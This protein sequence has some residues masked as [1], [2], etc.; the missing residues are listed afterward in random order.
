VNQVLKSTLQVLM[1]T[2]L[3]SRPGIAMFNPEPGTAGATGGPMSA[4]VSRPQICRRL[5]V[6]QFSSSF[7]ALLLAEAPSD[8]P[9]TR[10]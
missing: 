4:G 6:K 9:F 3:V 7:A 2:R 8:V 10:N 1:L 5:R